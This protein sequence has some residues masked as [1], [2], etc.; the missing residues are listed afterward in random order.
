MVYLN[1]KEIVDPGRT[2]LLVWDVQNLLVSRIFN[3][4]EFLKNLKSFITAVR[5]NNI[6]IIYT[7]HS[8]LPRKY[9]SSFRTLMFMKRFGFKDPEKVPQLPQPGSQAAEIYSDA[10][11]LDGDVVLNKNTTSVFIGTNF[12][13]MIRNR[14]IE[15]I[16]FTGISTDAGISSSARDSSNR[17][18][19]TIVVQDCVSSFNQEMHEAA[20]KALQSVCF[21]ES[22]EN[23]MKEWK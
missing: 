22:S 19:Y 4:E 8:P 9:E 15:T 17:G 7:K 21:V 5:T 16:L 23:I 2:A 11:P 14:C 10:S 3:K 1:L 12:E 6:S 18:F 13:N 20:L